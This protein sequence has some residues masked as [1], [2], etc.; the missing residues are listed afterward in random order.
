MVPGPSSLRFT[1]TLWSNPADFIQILQFLVE[2][3]K[4]ASNIAAMFLLQLPDRTGRH[5]WYWPVT[6]ANVFNAGVEQL[7]D[8]FR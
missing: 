7:L 1:G 2:I 5:D 3:V 4:H 6:S 8:A